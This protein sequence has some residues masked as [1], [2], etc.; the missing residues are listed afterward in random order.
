HIEDVEMSAAGKK[1]LKAELRFI[2]AFRYQDL[3]RNYGEVVLVGDNV[4][5]LG[6]DFTEGSFFKRSPIADGINYVVSALDA[7]APDRPSEHITS[8][9]LGIATNGVALALKSRLLIYAASPLYTGETSDA[10]KW[11]E[12]AKAAQDV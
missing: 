11:N 12:A 4:P 3:I 2:R 6:D 7:N 5:E 9:D 10:Q 1:L 8:G